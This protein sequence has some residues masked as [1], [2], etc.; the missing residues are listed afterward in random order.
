MYRNFICYRGGSSAG[1]LVAEELFA[2]IHKQRH[3]VGE[4]YFSP[5][6]DNPREIRN[7]LLDPQ[8]LLLNIENFVV[9]LTKD[10]FQDFY[11]DGTPNPNSVTRMEI[12][13]VLKNPSVKFIPVIFPDFAWSSK[14][15]GMENQEIIRSLWGEDA[16]SRIVGSP[17]IPFLHMY[18]QPVYKL[19]IE[20]LKQATKSKKVVVFDFD[21]TLTLP[22]LELNSWEVIWKTLGYDVSECEKYHRKFSNNEITHDEWCEITEKYFVAAGCKKSHI[23]EAASKSILVNDVKEVVSKM[24]AH[25]IL[26]YILS[27]SIKQYI[28]HVLGPDISACFEEIKANR[29]VFDDQGLLDGIIGTPYDFEG[30]ARFVRKIMAEKD[31]DP[32]D[33]LYVGNSFNDEFVYTTGVATLCINPRGTDFY[34]N[35]IWHNYIRNLS[36]LK[37]IL[38]FVYKE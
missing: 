17:P 9:L 12:D 31:V 24:K 29:F 8:K 23:K 3:Y 26:L 27:G 37:E 33:I 38:P 7:F 22:G 16:C 10:F 13:E 11:I 14:T 21:G 30:K 1:I 28:E 34:N 5:E 18:K 4:T 2:E 35:K 15:Y 19:V 32:R 36:S 25:G 6:K 20:E